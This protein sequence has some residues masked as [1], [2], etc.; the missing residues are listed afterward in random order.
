MS[1]MVSDTTT[2]GCPFK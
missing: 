1:T 2:S